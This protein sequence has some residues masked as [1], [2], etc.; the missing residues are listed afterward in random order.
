MDHDSRTRARRLGGL[1]ALALGLAVPTAAWA[2]PKDD[3]RRHFIAALEAVRAQDYPA[4]LEEFLAAQDVY[5][6]PNTLYNIAKVYE[7][8]GES[9]KAIE[10]FRLF[11]EAEPGKAADV[12]PMI[13]V[14]EGRIR[15]AQQQAAEAE[16]GAPEGGAAGAATLAEV[17]RLQAIAAELAALSE[18]L[19]GRAAEPVADAGGAPP[20]TEPGAAP[21]G[22]EAPPAADPTPSS[23]DDFLA[24]AYDRVVVTASRYGQDPLDSPSTVAILTGDDIRMSGATNLPDLLRR[25]AGVDVMSLSAA[26]PEL[27]IRGFNREMSNKVLVLIDGRST[28]KDMMVTTIWAT[29][30]V[31]LHD[32]ERIEIIRGPGS[33]VYGA[34]AMTGVINIITK[35]GGQ[36][37]GVVSVDAGSPG[38]AQGTAAVSGRSGDTGY[39]LSVG[40]HK[41]GRWNTSAELGGDSPLVSSAEDQDTSMDVVRALGRVDRAFS[42]DAFASMSGGYSGGLSEFYVFGTLGDYTLD[43]DSGFVRGDAGWKG[44]HFRTFYNFFRADAAPWL[45]YDGGRSLDTSVVDDIV[46]VELEQTASFETGAVEHT[47]NAGAGYRYKY[48]VWGYINQGQAVEQ[49]HFNA[50][51]QDQALVGPVRLV[52]SLRLDKHPLLALKETISPRGAVV[53]RVAERTSL[54]ATTGT[55][56]RA[57]S[58]MESFTDLNQPTSADGVFIRTKGDSEGIVPER[59]FTTEL[60]IH[61]ES[62]AYHRADVAAYV[63][64]VSDLIYVQDVVPPEADDLFYSPDERGFAGGTTSFGNLSPLYLSYGVEAE[65]QVFPVDGLDLFANVTLQRTQE[66][67]GQR[68]VVDGQTSAFKLNAGAA[69]RSPWRVDVS[70]QVHHLSPQ[71]WRLREFDETGALQVQEQEVGARTIGV[72]RLAARPFADDSLELS[73]TAWN[74]GSLISGQGFREHP[75]GQLVSSRLFGTATYRF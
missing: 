48:T 59:V 55:S 71:V 39:R 56:F 47:L 51:L 27:S 49:N 7:D 29:L 45:Q 67:D 20:D 28:Y 72:A 19:Q 68:T 65:A 3:A 34:N 73:M 10:Y 40:K 61:D 75:K 70:G 6:H 2:D 62:T 35:T 64:R 14:L 1:A 9:E 74:I 43:F 36:G 5:P 12:A 22:D 23:A 38:Y 16:A 63:N 57:P 30:P 52:G 17:E 31:S 41:T 50:F 11:A 26:Q 18:S 13:K 46:D 24:G 54:R 33:A 4:A 60:G 53:V 66:T 37:D 32:I 15:V 25:V 58:Q 21:S 69:W 8:M 44:L 42:E